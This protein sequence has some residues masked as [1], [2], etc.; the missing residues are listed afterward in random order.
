MKKT[1]LFIL[2]IYIP[3]I[4]TAT[5]D[6]ALPPGVVSGPTSVTVGETVQ[7][8]FTNGTIVFGGWWS[9]TLGNVTSTSQSGTD[10][11]AN[12]N[13]TTAGTATVYF[14]DE[15]DFVLGTLSVT[16]A[17]G[18]PAPN[19]TFTTAYNCNNTVIT[20]NTSPASGYDWYWQT[21]ASG[22]STTTKAA[23]YTITTS[24]SVY[25][26]TRQIASPYSWS[27]TSQQV[28]T[29]AVTVY[30]T[31]P[32]AP[33]TSTGATIFPAATVTISVGAVTGATGYK[34]YTVATG[35][36][37][38]SGVTG[39]TYQP[40]NVSVTTTYY[41]SA[42]NGPCESSGRKSV[43]LTVEPNPV[44]QVL[45]GASPAISFGRSI[46]I[47]ATTTFNTYSWKNSANVQIGTSST[48]PISQAG[49]YTVSVTKT[50]VTGTGTAMI[51]IA[52]GLAGQ[53]LNYVVTNVLQSAH[54]DATNLDGLPIDSI[55]QSVQYF[56]GLGR[57]AQAV[58]TQGSPL[59]KDIVQAVVYDEFGREAL[60][61]LPYVS[62]DATGWLKTNPVGTTSYTGSAHHSFYQG[63]SKVEVDNA[64]FAKTIFESNPMGRV[65]EQGGPGTIWQPDA[66][67]SYTSTDK[68]VKSDYAFNAASEVLKWSFTAPTSSTPYG[69]VLCTSTATST[70]AVY[71][72]A[73]E[74][75]KNRT[76][77]EQGFEIIQYT[78]KN[79]K[80][81]LKR[82][83]VK[84]GTVND[85]NYTST[86]YIYDDLGNLV[87]V[88][89][90]E[91]VRR[92]AAEYYQSGATNTTRERFLDKWAFRY[93]F[94]NYNRMKVKKV[95]AAK[96]VYMVYDNL[97]RIVL[98]QD[99]NQRGSSTGTLKKEWLFTKYDFLNRPIMSGI[100]TH[101]ANDTAQAEMQ[102]YVNTLM[103]SGNQFYED[104]NGVSSSD[105]YTNRVFPTS[106]KTTYT[107]TYYDNYKFITPLINGGNAAITTYNF[108]TG[109]L[110][111]QETQAAS[112]V[113]GQVTGTKVNVLGTSTYLWTVSYYDPKYRAIQTIS[114]NH[115][116]GVDRV[117]NKY[118]FVKLT[119]TKS[120]HTV[121]STTYATTRRLVY[122]HAGRLLKTYHKI[123][124]DAEIL[125]SENEYNELG[126]L[127]TKKLHSR[128][129]GP[130][131]QTVDYRY[132]IRGWMKQI[133]DVTAPDP[134][135][136]F[137]MDLRYNNPTASGG[138]AQFNGN[139]SE[140]VWKSAGLDKQSYGYYYDTLNRLKEARYF[141]AVKTT[142]NGRFNEVIGGVNNKGYDLNGNIVKLSRYGR[143]SE[144][145]FGQM[146]NL[147]YSYSGNQ[148]TRV[149]DA[150]ATNSFE[151]GFK[152]ITEVAGEYTYDVNGSMIKDQNKDISSIEY[153]HLNLPKKVIKTN[154]DYITYTYDAT[155]R[156]LSQ[157]VYA[158]GDKLLKTTDY[159]G[160]FTYENDGLQFISHED[161]R[162]V[163]GSITPP[164]N[165]IPAADGSSLSSFS[166]NLNVTRTVETI[167]EETY[168][169]VVCNQTAPSPGVSPIGS[170][171]TVVAGEKY[172]FRVRG[173]SDTNAAAHLY[174][175]TNV[176][177]IW[178]G[179]KL[180]QRADN[181]GWI[182]VEFT[183]PSGATQLKVGVL[184]PA[185]VIGATMYINEVM[186]HRMDWEYQYFLK[187]HLGNNRV[188]F[189]ERKTTTEYKATFES[190]T[191]TTEQSTFE[192]YGNRSA[193]NLYDHTD[194]GATALT[195]TYSQILNGGNSS[196][197]G[198]AKSFE[199][200]P[201]DVLDLEVYAKYEEPTTTGNNVNAL[202]SSL[203]AAFGLNTTSSN[204][205]DGQQAYNAFNSTFSA[206]PY[207]G[208]V[209][210]YEDGAAPKA[211]LNYILFN[212]NFEL[213]DF[214]FDQISTTAKQV[215]ASPFVTH[216]LLALH[217]KV[218]K[219]GYLYI[220]LSNEQAVQ[221]NVY[222]DDV[223]ITYHTGVEQV[224]DY[225]PFGLTFNSSSKGTSVSNLY[226]YNGKEEQDELG[227]GWLDYGARMYMA[228]IG[229]WGVVDPMAEKGRRHSLYNYA[230]NNPV[231]FID[232]DGMWPE[233]S[234]M[235]VVHTSLDVVGLVPGLG[236]IADG[237]NAVAYL[238][239]GNY[240]D[241]A[242]SAAAMVPFAG[243][244]STVVKF[245]KNA[246]KVIT[247]VKTAD[248]AATVKKNA[249][250]G[251]DFEKV[252][253]GDL[254][255][256]G[257]KDIAE[258]VTI[259]A[260]NGTKTRVDNISKDKD[261]KIELTEAKSSETAP[262]TKNQKSA[263][264]SIEQ[265]GGTVVGDNGK[266]MGYPAG[267]KIP[268]T[269]VDVV[270]PK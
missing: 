240:E 223:K 5:T 12:I 146:D 116:G 190:G 90:P 206:G 158:A 162:I 113:T 215:G 134:A 33:T 99:G 226:Q 165:K 87:C 137:S 233:L 55:T 194:A 128:S 245:A 72:A 178:P 74:L 91:G 14:Y 196:Q 140:I 211:Y 151:E 208:R 234:I 122:D 92:L 210:P 176:N 79:G 124:S 9:A 106:G 121:G 175:W 220:Y 22:T 138:T 171:F 45:N 96:P 168:V 7:Y 167:N 63:T 61:Y 237:I 170:V 101:T 75:Y 155:G 25:L 36:T 204:P 133:N 201:G 243:T 104:Y 40:A 4:V 54:K 205:L 135:D 119:E 11:F 95:P 83:Q 166:A 148:L 179:P 78:D 64:P 107:A 73:N 88:I 252:V 258:Q 150:I 48:T 68:T 221:T 184:W 214:G 185:P 213:E 244:A 193:F 153:N 125:L 270:R 129:S 97:D 19:T 123:N 20:R 249:E 39:T 127:V 67:N 108:Q 62:S 21:S 173:Y 183:I 177:S 149:D 219:K 29:S 60:K 207:I 59:K 267:T 109:D 51:S 82:A 174:V 53:S 261:G 35:G 37:A 44:I 241:A 15:A 242:L 269:K 65:L 260:D 198:L 182:T 197:V 17:A 253:T 126:E 200:Q 130:F 255:K 187:D 103:V 38:I 192:N 77:D 102:A 2:A 139:I 202:A 181:E 212:E 57:L 131:V 6:H 145:G 136:L 58:Q 66:T 24:S 8:K 254:A 172:V 195:Y 18:I 100:Y 111:G 164:I 27:A 231:R 217:V 163:P 85:T 10:Y 70:T 250:K 152:E 238:A 256:K 159:L 251:K 93:V 191:Q 188:V 224:E 13:W 120:T 105:G 86:Y 30:T 268:P 142:N 230:F 160:E 228:D 203:I 229:R 154:S 112:N 81:V 69:I 56:D 222:F 47:G 16:V 209:P 94:D 225:Y 232:P 1:F 189:S 186:L 262:L 143:N 42:L 265:N 52:S 199:V 26:R 236:E 117:T 89:Q 46:T 98:T 169:K 84:A 23:S 43:V 218:Q 157:M 28:G 114:Q 49:T 76:K 80:V 31:T 227:L 246:D 161:G 3:L 34:W 71:Y 141:N 32:S 115:K 216:D 248:K 235:D 132:N 257:N 41:V 144:T 156:K 266:N 180:S 50:G 264:P 110:T 118:D 147:T 263:H 239:E 247:A 259:K